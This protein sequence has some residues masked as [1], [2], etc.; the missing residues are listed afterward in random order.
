M[1]VFCDFDGTISKEDVT[2][3][4]LERFALPEWHEIE[5]QWIDGKITSAQ[6][7]RRQVRLIEATREELDA[8]LDTIE[9]DS[10]FVAFKE[11]C[12]RTGLSLIIVSDGV[13]H[14]ISRVLARHGLPDIQIIANRLVGGSDAGKAAFDLDFPFMSAACAGG[15][16]VCKCDLV[17]PS[18]DQIYVGDGRSDFCVSHEPMLV[19]A[20]AKLA[21]YCHA[22]R[23]P[24][25]PYDSFADIQASVAGILSS[26]SR[27]SF[28]LPVAKS[29]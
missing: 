16:G 11:F 28:A 15:S 25:I 23:I 24:F 9:I 17:K 1:Q 14:F 8:F 13:D 4:V 3:L 7:M 10:A 5:D 20:K 6:C 21:D 29:A 2:D 19:F 26:P 22:Q 27:Q 18:G 12:E